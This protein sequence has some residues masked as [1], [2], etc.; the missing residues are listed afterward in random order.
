MIDELIEDLELMSADGTEVLDESG[1]EIVEG[2][3]FAGEDDEV[4]GG[5]A[6]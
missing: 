3:L 2:L 6:D 4:G 1:A 5:E